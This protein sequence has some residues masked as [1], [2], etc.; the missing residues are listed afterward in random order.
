[1][2]LVQ[3]YL[4]EGTWVNY[5]RGVQLCG[6]YEVGKLLR[7]LLEY[8]MA[9][10]S[11]GQAAQ[12]GSGTPTKEQVMASQRRQPPT[13][14]SNARFTEKIPENV[15]MLVDGLDCKRADWLRDMHTL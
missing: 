1:M 13:Q 7:P 15:A 10:D 8:D 14:P 11:L 9:P 12:E 3:N 6:Q 4:A 5:Q 2:G